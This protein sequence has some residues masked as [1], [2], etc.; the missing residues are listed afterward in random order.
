MKG[1]RENLYREENINMTHLKDIL[2]A[3]QLF[4]DAESR[5]IFSVRLDY[6]LGKNHF[7]FVDDVPR[8]D[9]VCEEFRKYYEK[10]RGDRIIVYGAGDCGVYNAKV[11]N[12]CGYKVEAFCDSDE[13]LWGNEINHIPVISLTQLDE[14]KDN[15]V[16]V[17]SSTNYAHIGQIYTRLLERK[18]T[19]ERIFCS[20]YRM[21]VATRGWQYFDF[22]RPRGKEIFVDGGVLDGNT[23]VEF[24]KWAEGK[25]EKIYMFEA[26]NRNELQ[27]LNTMKKNNMRSYDLILKGLSDRNDK[28]LFDD[29]M[30]GGSRITSGNGRL[31]EVTSI[32]E[33]IKGEVSFIKMDIEGAESAALAGAEQTIK[34]CRPRLAISVYH[35]E[36][37]FVSIP[38]LL[39]KMNPQYQFAL[40][41]Y[42]AS[43]NET[44]LYAW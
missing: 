8:D 13:R 24:A 10:Y 23:S 15:A 44:V 6:L 30:E 39:L 12:L 4:A 34:R 5:E 37:D 16:V 7:L 33:T 31:I 3:E 9:Y 36:D 11:L 2:R 40:R 17:I 1:H 29:G 18:F 21:L 22:F 42:T 41:H 43:A 26:N 14:C 20:A 19:R 27:I 35:K 32:D 28:V 25:Y 38:L